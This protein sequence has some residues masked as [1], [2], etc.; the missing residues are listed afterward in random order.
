MAEPILYSI[1]V[2]VYGVEAY[3]NRC[4]DSLIGQTYYNIEIILVDDGA[5]DRS[6]EICDHYAAL[7]PRVKVLH[8]K[9]GGVVSARK[10]GAQLATGEYI[11]C[12][13]GDDW[14]STEYVRLFDEAICRHHPD[15]VCCG[16]IHTTQEAELGRVC[17]I[18]GGFYGPEE[19][20]QHI[21]PIAIESKDGVGLAPHVWAKAI[22]RELFVPQQMA[23]TDALK[24]GE[25]GAMI[26]SILPRATSLYM[27]GEHLYYYRANPDSATKASAFD[28]NM[29]RDIYQHLKSQVD[30]NAFDYE[31]QLYRC[32]ARYLYT[33]VYSQFHR[34]A[35]Y[36]QIIKD[37][38]AQLKQPDY[39]LVLQRARYASLKPRLEVFLMRHRILLPIWLLHKVTEHER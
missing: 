31:Q 11:L 23:V 6:P 39:R 21:Y 33:V 35:S 15:L 17:P 26:K 20:K 38:K 4:V 13:D 9:N 25:D 5:Q 1:V 28:W 10:A 19:M 8:K 7:D 27:I 32:I 18:P 3:L 36:R 34:Q 24:I 22:R 30:L 16:Y 29:P 12:V 2:P 14:V 37:I